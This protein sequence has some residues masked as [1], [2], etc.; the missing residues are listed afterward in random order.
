[1]DEQELVRRA[2][3]GEGE[4]LSLL[5]E[6]HVDR[7]YRYVVIRVGNPHDA[8]DLTEEVF[9]RALQRIDSFSY[10]VAPLTA[11]LSRIAHNLS[12]DHWRRSGGREAVPLEAA[13]SLPSPGSDPAEGLERLSDLQGLHTALEALTETQRE[14]LSLRFGADLSIAETA[15]AMHRKEGTIKALQHHALAALRRVLALEGALEERHGQ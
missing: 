4:A 11:W 5:Y 9:V 12:G 15:K 7:I 13:S 6:R 14:V 8:E 1:V 2:Q 3:A 10:R